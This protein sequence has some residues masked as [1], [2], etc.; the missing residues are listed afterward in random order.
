MDH[1]TF[2]NVE[3]AAWVYG[4]IEKVRSGSAWRSAWIRTYRELGGQSTT[5]GS[6]PCPMVA[7]ETL[8]RLGRIKGGG[9]AFVERELDE[10]WSE[11][12]NGTYAVL[13]VRI[14]R[15][16]GGLSQARLWKKVQAVVR[17]EIGDEPAASNQGGATLAY[18]LWHL[19]L[20]VG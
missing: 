10:L 5:S 12:R 7:A 2:L 14:L 17:R 3:I 6:K 11:N 4:T 16:D 18:K 13:A 9:T 1:R 15:L 19:G 20:I 8:Y